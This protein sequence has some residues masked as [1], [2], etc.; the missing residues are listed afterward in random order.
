MCLLVLAGCAEAPAE[1]SLPLV[2]EDGL[3]KPAELLGHWQVRGRDDFPLE[4]DKW[5]LRAD[6]VAEHVEHDILG[7][8][9]DERCS[10]GVRGERFEMDCPRHQQRGPFRLDGGE[11][12]FA[13]LRRA[14]P[15]EL[16]ADAATDPQDRPLI[17][18][19]ISEI[20]T[21]SD[22]AFRQEGR[23]FVGQ[24]SVLRLFDDY[25]MRGE[26]IN[27]SGGCTS[28][29]MPFRASCRI[30]DELLRCTNNGP[31]R[32]PDEQAYE[33][34]TATLDRETGDPVFEGRALSLTRWERA[35]AVE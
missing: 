32:D 15:E 33:V 25:T 28:S 31:F 6:G 20:E 14:R 26:V 35:V 10:W 18:L 17:G 9:R 7:E 22:H 24:R 12:S 16:E 29:I 27:D 5:L 11:L 1:V 30:D 2:E 21:K 13:P 23:W 3:R 4:D 34:I 19:W 8:R